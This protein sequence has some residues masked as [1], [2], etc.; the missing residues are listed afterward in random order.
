MLHRHVQGE[1]APSGAIGIAHDSGIPRS[2]PRAE[3]RD[4]TFGP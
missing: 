2:A 1:C 3:E 4:A